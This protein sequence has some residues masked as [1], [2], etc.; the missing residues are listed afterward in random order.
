MF[1]RAYRYDGLQR[2]KLSLD[3]F[4]LKD[5]SLESSEDLP[6]SDLIA[7]EIADLPRPWRVRGDSGGVGR[8]LSCPT[9]V[10]RRPGRSGA[11]STTAGIPDGSC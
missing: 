4:W 10:A 9:A 3:I 2:E 6:D 8:R 7:A 5:E 11:R 1:L